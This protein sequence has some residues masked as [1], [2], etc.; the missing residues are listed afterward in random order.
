MI[1]AVLS[2]SFIFF[3]SLSF[4]Q[5]QTLL[6][7][8]PGAKSE[9]AQAE[10]LRGLGAKPA[11]QMTAQTA[12][13]A[14]TGAATQ[15][16]PPANLPNEVVDA[17]KDHA[18]GIYSDMSRPLAGGFIQEAWNDANASAGVRRYQYC[19]DCSYK[20]RLREFMISQIHLP[21][22]EAIKAIDIGDATAFAV[23][24]R[25]KS[26]V[27]I[28]PKG[29]GM[30]SNLMILTQNEQS[31][32]ITNSYVFYLR[33]ERFNSNHIPDLM[34]KIGDAG[35]HAAKVSQLSI[36]NTLPS[37]IDPDSHV[38][39]SDMAIADLTQDAGEEQQDD[40]LERIQFDPS[41]IHGFDDYTL[42]GN[43]G[44]EQLRPLRIF[45][46][47]QFTYL[48][49]DKKWDRLELPTAYVV[50]DEIDELVNTRVIGRTY[51]IE[52]I[53]ALITLKS[54]EAY[55]CIQYEGEE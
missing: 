2:L 17:A 46:D 6:P 44:G 20:V 21:E 39:K 45:R 12:T 48:Q 53:H 4:A 32:D 11:T 27:V 15:A 36:P 28:K 33:S 50:V 24:Q 55:L 23:E 19:R 25:T 41:K 51:I 26:I 52:S 31:P 42:W 37:F 18:N 54:G 49:F 16:S 8:R 30:D 29:F 35:I 3:L 7:V 10:R 38:T 43:K 34:V 14:V 40:Y 5:A 22:G 47:G 1:R 13:Q 9:A